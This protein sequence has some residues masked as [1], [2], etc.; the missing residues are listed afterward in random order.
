MDSD[1]PQ[2]RDIPER[3]NLQPRLDTASLE[4]FLKEMEA[5]QV[6]LENF[7]GYENNSGQVDTDGEDSNNYTHNQNSY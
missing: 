4:H 3:V 5:I 1:L 7:Q 2:F 6:C